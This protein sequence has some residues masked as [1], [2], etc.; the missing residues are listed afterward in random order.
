MATIKTTR[1]VDGRS[2]SR[3]RH[4]RALSTRRFQRGQRHP[5]A[6][7]SNIYLG[8]S[9][10]KVPVVAS[11]NEEVASNRGRRGTP[12]RSAHERYQFELSERPI[13][14]LICCHVDTGR[15]YLRRKSMNCGQGMACWTSATTYEEFVWKRLATLG[16][17][18]LPSSI[19]ATQHRLKWT[20]DWCSKCTKPLWP[21]SVR[22]WQ[23][24]QR[25]YS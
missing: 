14:D 3:T 22:P 10:H 23:L 5:L 8:R 19:F 21:M 13:D 15:S 7:C 24:F 16:N 6:L 17:R 2:L 18:S 20:R 11:E 25:I 12:A 1:D 9:L 4:S